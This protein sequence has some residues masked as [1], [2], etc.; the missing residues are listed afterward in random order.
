MSSRLLPLVSGTKRRQKKKVR[1]VMPPNTQKA[2]ACVNPAS[3]KGWSSSP[4]RHHQVHLYH[5]VIEECWCLTMSEKN[6]VTRKARVQLKV[7]E[8]EEATD[9]TW[10]FI[11]GW[12]WL[13]FYC[14]YHQTNSTSGA[15]SSLIM[16]QGIGPKPREKANTKTDSE[17]NGTWAS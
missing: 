1:M 10:I 16:S 15:N 11:P 6:L 12:K 14:I 17:I 7:V 8:I 3:W 4:S 9:F 5:Q 2:P 13:Y